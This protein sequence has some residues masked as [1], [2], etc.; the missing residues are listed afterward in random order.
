[1]PL[2][3]GNY[4]SMCNKRLLS[5]APDFSPVPDAS[6]AVYFNRFNGFLHIAEHSQ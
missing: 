4:L 5:L 2:E 6:P 1:M 3:K